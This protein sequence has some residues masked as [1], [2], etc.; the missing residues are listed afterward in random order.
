[1]PSRLCGLIGAGIQRSLAPALQEGEARHHG[2]DLRY[3]LFDLD[4]LPGGTQALPA[5]IADVRSQGFAGVNVTYP[6][7]Q[8]VIPLLDGLSA[9]A[10]A[11]GAV[12]TVVREGEQLI[13]HNTDG[14]GWGW[15]FRRALPSADLSRVAL[16]G[17]GGAGSA[18]AD[19]LLRLGVARLSIFDSESKRAEAL[20]GKLN[21]CFENR[22]IA[23]VKSPAEA[24]ADATGV[25]HATPVGMAKHPGLPF[26]AELLR[27]GLWLSEVVYVPLETELLQ[28]A[29]RAGCATMHGGHM[30]VGQALGAF[31]LFTGADADPDRV[32][33]HFLQLARSL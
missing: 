26:P 24:L 2:I 14:P 7:K 8:S 15:G 3:R 19:A 25:V 31:K 10:A 22:K 29:R 20:A 23:A 16:I 21:A 32:Q 9:E 6:C 13:G 4:L 28:A 17:A 27:A 30:N 5:L 18:C 11:I 12:N 1:V 33:A